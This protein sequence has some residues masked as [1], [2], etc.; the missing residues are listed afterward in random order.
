MEATVIEN[1]FMAKSHTGTVVTNRGTTRTVW[2]GR[3][4][5]GLVTLFMCF[6]LG[7]K[8]LAL[9]VAVEGTTALGYPAAVVVPLGL[10]Q[11]ACLILY[12]VPRTALIGALLWTAYLGGAVATHVRVGNPLFTHV[13]SPVYF[14]AMLWLG[15]WLRDRRVGAFLAAPSLRR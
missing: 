2:A 8:I 10:I 14:A 1:V 12:L 13:L 9:P 11:L 7:V 4:L 6:D 5:T 3:I 15:L